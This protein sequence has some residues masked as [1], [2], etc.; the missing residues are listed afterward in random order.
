[1]SSLVSIDDD[2]NNSSS[3]IDDLSIAS[4]AISSND[5]NDANDTNIVVAASSLPFPKDGIRLSS[6]YEFYDICGG[7]NKL[8]GLTTT[9]VNEMYQ[10]PLTAASGLS[11]CE[12]LKS[13]NSVN[14]GQAVVFISH[15]KYQFLSPSSSL[16][17]PLLLLLSSSILS[18]FRLYE[19]F[20]LPDLCILLLTYYLL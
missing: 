9:D 3:N 8:I 7:K 12:Y 6:L 11:Y 4:L 14:V 5:A 17:L 15:G 13:K 16:S 10:K 2:N 1:M 18:S 20:L 19:S